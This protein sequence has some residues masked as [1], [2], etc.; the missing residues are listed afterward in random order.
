MRRLLKRWWF[1][2][3]FAGLLAVISRTLLL[4]PH[5]DRI[6]ELTE[7]IQPGLTKAQVIAIMGTDPVRV[8]SVVNSTDA[9][10]TVHETCWWTFGD[11]DILVIFQDGR[12]LHHRVRRPATFIEQVQAWIKRHTPLMWLVQ[13]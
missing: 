2:A 5:R 1:W 9:Y 6:S 3:L 10:R 8:H 7:K 12:V 11:T 4:V 13:R